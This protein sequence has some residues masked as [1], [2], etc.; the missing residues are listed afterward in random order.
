AG[1]GRLG[2]ARAVSDILAAVPNVTAVLVRARGLWGSSFSFAEGTRPPLM[3]RLLQGA[4]VYLSN[5]IVFTPKRP[6]TMTVEAFPPGTRPEPTREA[7]NRWLEAWFNAD[8]KP[9]TPSY[10]PYHFAFGPRTHEY[11]PPGSAA[12]AALGEGEVKPAT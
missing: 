4:G 2:G 11:P 9:E 1:V 12:G 7:V 5:L 10:V 3:K 6:V 8:Q